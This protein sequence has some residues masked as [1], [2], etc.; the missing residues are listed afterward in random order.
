MGYTF[1]S[2]QTADDDP[3]IDFTSGID[4]TYDEYLFTIVNYKPETDSQQICFQVDTGTNTSYNQTIT[5]T[6]FY[7]GTSDTGGWAQVVYAGG[8]DQ[9]EGDTALQILTYGGESNTIPS[10]TNSGELRLY[11]PSSSAYIKHF[12][13]SVNCIYDSSGTRYNI[14]THTA[15]YVNTTTALTRVRFAASSDNIYTGTFTLYG[16]S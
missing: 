16:V 13:A 8:H 2:S 9:A 15:G 6:S 12:T 7:A 14:T 3:S 4:G 1:L 10:L 5:S 11:A